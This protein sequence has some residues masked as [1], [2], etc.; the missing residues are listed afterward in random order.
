MLFSNDYFHNKNVYSDTLL[1]M[2]K[3]LHTFVNG[4]TAL[5]HFVLADVA[6]FPGWS[7]SGVQLVCAWRVLYHLIVIRPYDGPVRKSEKTV[8]AIPSDHVV[9]V[10]GRRPPYG[11]HVDLGRRVMESL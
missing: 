6:V 1:V 4:V 9:V 8:V 11:D 7:K 5:E 10:Y 3:L 2:E